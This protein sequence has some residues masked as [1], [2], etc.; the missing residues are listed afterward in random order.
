VAGIVK[1]GKRHRYIGFLIQGLEG[2]DRVQRYVMLQ[3]INTS[4][5]ELYNVSPKKMGIYLTR[6]NGAEGILRCSHL[7]KER[8]IALLRSIQQ[9]SGYTVH[10]ETLGTSGTINKLIKKH[11]S[12][13]VED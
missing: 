5:K 4:C 13:A 12:S 10:I 7:E 2:K 3:A 9:L 6:F 8:T 11:M 1:E